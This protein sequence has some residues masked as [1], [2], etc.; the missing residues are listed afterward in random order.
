MGKRILIIGAG[1]VGTVVAHKCAQNRDVFEH[2]TLASRTLAKPRKIAESIEEKGHG[3]IEIAEVNA[4]SAEEVALLIQKA[5]PDLLINVALPYQDLSIMDACLVTKTPYIDTANYEPPYEAK[6]EY[7]WQWAYRE[8]FKN[9]GLTALLGAGFDPG[10]TNVFTAYLARYRFD[11]VE[12]LDI[13]DC[14]AG[15]HGYPFATNFNPEINIREVTQRGKYWERLGDKVFDQPADATDWTAPEWRETPPLS[16]RV[17]FDYPVVGT[18]PTYLMYH[19]ELESLV[20]TI[21]GLRRARFW[22]TFGDQYLTHLRVLKNVGMTSITPI[23][24]QGKKVIPIEFLKAI[25]PEP[26]SLGPR[27]TGKTVIGCVVTGM[28]EGAKKTRYLY[29]V[30]DHEESFRE[31]GAQAISYTTGVPT[32]TAAKMLLTGTCEMDAG[33]KNIEEFDPKPV[34][35]ELG[36]MGL[37]WKEIELPADFEIIPAEVPSPLG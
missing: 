18:K 11:S 21:P 13:L 16:R 32:V 4:D 36:T 17:D 20:R 2:I 15:D 28:H 3:S 19:E 24:F 22:M 6:F 10:A 1:G 8:K 5:K 29:Q 9:A 31:T 12:T 7:K 27:T 23:D 35:E 34:S 14:N 26:A 30:C 33:L 25:L 37:P